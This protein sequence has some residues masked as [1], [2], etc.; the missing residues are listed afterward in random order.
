M[1]KAMD[2]RSSM[3]FEIGP[4]ATQKSS[5]RYAKNQWSG[6]SNDGRLVQMGQQPNRTGNDGSCHHSGMPQGGHKPPT[7][8]TP[9]L[10]AQGSRRDNINRGHQ[11]RG[12]GTAMPRTG[13]TM[14][15]AGRGPTRG[16]QQ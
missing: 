3:D 11:V 5:T 15:N 8:A 2:Q 9:S 7:A 10:P 4:S 6:H 1:K 12:G 13:G 16:N 14:F